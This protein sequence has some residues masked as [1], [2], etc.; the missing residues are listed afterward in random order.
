MSDKL[1]ILVTSHQS[2]RQKSVKKTWKKLNDYSLS[3]S[4]I[5]VLQYYKEVF[6]YVKYQEVKTDAY[7][8]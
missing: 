2:W 1:V 7:T 5:Q 4:V 6:N 8:K 3:K